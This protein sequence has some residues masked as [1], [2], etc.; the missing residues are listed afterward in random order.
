MNKNVLESK[1]FE[2]KMKKEDQNQGQT[3]VLTAQLTASSNL[4]YPKQDLKLGSNFP[5]Q[6]YN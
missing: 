3:R 5:K 1:T 4:G 6:N 2:N